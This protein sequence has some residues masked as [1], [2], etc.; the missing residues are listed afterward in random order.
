MP[1][2]HPVLIGV[3]LDIDTAGDTMAGAAPVLA[4]RDVEATGRLDREIVFVHETAPGLPHG[5][6][7]AVEQAFRRLVD[8]GVL[9][10][11]G[12]AVSMSRSTPIRTGWAP[13]TPVP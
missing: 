6:A 13:G 3:L 7:F 12:P 10:I 2:A 1:G 9:A 8:R 11:V 5:S 4:L